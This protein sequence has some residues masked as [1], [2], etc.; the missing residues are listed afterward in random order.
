MSFI[1]IGY[2]AALGAIAIPIV[3]HLVFRQKARRVDLGTLRFLKVVLEQNARR[4]RVMRYLLLALRLACVAVLALLFARPYLLAFRSA[5]EKPTVAV[6]IDRSATMELARD[7]KRLV[8]AAVDTTKQLL[9]RGADDTRFEIAFFDHAVRPLWDKSGEASSDELA[10]LSAVELAELL[11]APEVCAGGTDYGAALE[12]ARDVL[13]KAPPGPRHLHVFTDLQ[14]SGLA[15]SEVD[16]LPED[17]VTHLHDL[18]RSAVNNI[19][20]VEARVD[21]PWLRP[22]QQTS[23]HVTIYNGSPFTAEELPIALRMK[24]AG[25]TIELR[26]R[27]KI[28]G[29]ASESLRF[30]LPPMEE[31]LWEGS[32]RVETEDDLALDNERSIA[33]LAS[34]P[35]Q[36][37]L[38]D[39]RSATSPLLAATY[40]LETS[41]R[42]GE[43]GELDAGSKFEPR[44]VTADEIL[45][46]LEKFDVV[47]LADVGELDANNARKLADFVDRGG[48]LLVFSGENVTAARTKTLEQAGLTVG[49]IT[50][51]AQA[52]DLPLRL[53]SWDSK[54]PIFSAFSDPQLGDLARLSF[55]ACTMLEPAA[56][57]QVLAKFRD[58]R[59]A[60]IERKRGKGSVVWFASSC[61]GQWSD[62]TRSRL[63]LPVMHQLLGY[64]TGQTAGGRVRHAV[65]EGATELAADTQPGVLPLDRYWLV[66]NT[67]PRESETD[68]CSPEEFINRFGLHLQTEDPTVAAET[69]QARAALGTELIDSELWHWFAAFLLGILVLEGLIA[70]RTAA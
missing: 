45:P 36:V 30:D 26:E 53:G 64:Q 58:D 27:L 1:Q 35:Y 46:S 10:D 13:A 44:R 17:V 15:W 14:Q 63:Y 65:L 67:S 20:V 3:I 11:V 66:V 23:V 33:I 22:K 12:W 49:Q 62:W 2:L 70:N 8:D 37:L 61:D 57:A 52:T 68:R 4:R 31:G 55:S 16:A 56:D 29:G 50:G 38:V 19:A 47:V 42:L 54:H 9:H 24:S 6:L 39:G 5:S 59:P 60:V 28:D 69:P 41:L 40:F 43:Q 21:R 51:I 25:R 48:G 34:Q 18:G 32:A 7:G